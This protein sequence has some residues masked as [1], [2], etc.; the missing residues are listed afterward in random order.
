MLVFGGV[1]FLNQI[2]VTNA[3]GQE[4]AHESANHCL[5]E[6]TNG[7]KKNIPRHQECLNDHDSHVG[8]FLVIFFCLVFLGWICGGVFLKICGD[9]LRLLRHE[10]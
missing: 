4:I 2:Q 1:A 7:E 9:L 8:N 6:P 10:T 5:K 3:L